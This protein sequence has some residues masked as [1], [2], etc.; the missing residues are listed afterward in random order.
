M[1]KDVNNDGMWNKQPH[2]PFHKC[3]FNENIIFNNYGE[4]QC[5]RMSVIRDLD[6]CTY[7]VLVL[8][9]TKSFFCH[10]QHHPILCA[11][12][13]QLPKREMQMLRASRAAD[14]SAL[15]RKNDREA[16]QSK[17]E[18]ELVSYATNQWSDAAKKR[19]VM[20]E[21][22]R[23]RLYGNGRQAAEEER[24]VWAYYMG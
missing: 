18:R 22:C 8:Y 19:R 21:E 1:T 24:V 10:V 9:P 20:L 5:Y 15:D 3:I 23:G 4:P 11:R 14:T 16:I 17:W 2:P 12:R 7:L 6:V 13:W